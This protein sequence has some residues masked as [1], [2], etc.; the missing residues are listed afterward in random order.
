MF[1]TII[2]SEK[3]SISHWIAPYLAKRYSGTS[4][5][6]FNQGLTGVLQFTFPRGRAF[7]EYPLVS[8]PR[9]Q[10][11][12]PSYAH[13]HSLNEYLEVEKSGDGQRYWNT[14]A[15]SAEALFNA[16]Q[17]AKHFVYAADL[18]SSSAHSYLRFLQY[19]GVSD[20]LSKTDVYL[21]HSLDDKTLKTTL[22]LGGTVELREH[23]EQLGRRGE[24]K[25]YF[26]WN[27][28]HNALV[29]LRQPLTAMGLPSDVVVSKYELQLLYFLAKNPD[30]PRDFDIDSSRSASP[31][32]PLQPFWTE[33]GIFRA[34]T[35]WK[36]SGKYEKAQLGSATSRDALIS[37]LRE[38]GFLAHTPNGR[39]LRITEQGYAFLNLLHPDCED[40]DLPARIDNWMEQGLETSQ[41]AIDRYIRSYFG[42]QIRFYSKNYPRK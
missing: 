5:L 13:A 18:H 15:L 6:L 28:N 19:A 10:F 7:S 23:L 1:E 12:P 2:V 21:L 41:G 34:M 38:K 39:R 20:A 22:S 32:I 25:R 37:H 8:A 11:N 4:T 36:G 30:Q 33:G 16:V 26:E 31:H 29:V 24:V 17:E 35:S 42:K 9:Y 3:P 40:L 27:W 14:P